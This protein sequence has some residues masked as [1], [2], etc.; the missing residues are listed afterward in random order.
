LWLDEVYTREIVRESSLAGLWRHVRATESTPPLYY[1]IGWTL[2]ARSTVAMR[3]ISAVSLI[4]AVPVGY[5]A[6][7]RLIGSTPALAT[8]AILAVTPVLVSYSTDARSY[9][10]FV[11]VS[12]LSLWAFARLLEDN[13][14]RSFV[15]WVVMSAA[16][17]WTHYFGVFV[18]GAE[19]V[20]LLV[21]HPQLRRAT[22]GWTVLL[23]VCLL[24]LIPLVTSQ[25]GDERAGFIVATPLT[26]R[27]ADAVRQFAMG[28]N[29]PRAWLEGAGL[30]VVCISVLVGVVMAVRYRHGPRVL[31]ALAVITLATPLLMAALGIA[32]RFYTRNV[33]AVVPIAAALAAP[34]MLRLRAMPL[35][36]YLGLAT[37]TS[38]WVAINW[39]Y[40]QA[41]WK[42]VLAR[43]ETIDRSVP[44]VAV[45]RL[46][47]PVAQTYLARPP[48]GPSGVIAQ[49]AWIVVEP[50]RAAGH[51]ALAPAPTPSLPGF[52]TLRTLEVHG[53][54]LILVG[55]N[56]PTPIAP[57]ELADAAVFAGTATETDQIHR[58]AIG[59]LRLR[60]DPPTW[61]G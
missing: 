7:R 60:S 19:I 55:A 27:L 34:A 25:S 12:L 38:A 40:E 18:V 16:S 50:V 3:S 48:A 14:S 52:A 30:A 43:A 24:P 9:S 8:S 47:A 29:V 17:V 1:L 44:I 57:A 23:G 31:L 4:A 36:I 46:G 56:Q 15:L 41:D 28:P 49:R 59:R 53:F 51:R 61:A 33:I 11:L 58:H 54:R 26:Q 45:T 13:S 20:V 5:L 6:F 10:L 42:A 22:I 2:H 37:A 35:A 32:D 21:A 39:R